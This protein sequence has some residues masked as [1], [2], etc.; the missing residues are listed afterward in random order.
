M[1][2]VIQPHYDGLRYMTIK[3]TNV[4][5]Y[6]FVCRLTDVVYFRFKGI[7]LIALL[8]THTTSSNLITY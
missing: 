1:S 6:S 3:Q 4:L 5:F 8:Y 2:H 7:S